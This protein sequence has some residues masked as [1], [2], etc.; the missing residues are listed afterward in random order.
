[1]ILRLH[2]TGIGK[3]VSTIVCCRNHKREK[4]VKL[5]FLTEVEE[6]VSWGNEKQVVTWN[7]KYKSNWKVKILQMDSFIDLVDIYRRSGMY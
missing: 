2:V 4:K 3:M 1:M 6:E 5:C 7:S